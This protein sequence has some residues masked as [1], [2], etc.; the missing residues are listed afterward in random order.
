MKSSKFQAPSSRETSNSKFQ[1]IGQTRLIFARGCRFVAQ[2]CN[3]LYRRIEFCGGAIIATA[4]RF[5][6]A[7]RLQIGDTA[8]FNS[9]LHSDAFAQFQKGSNG[10]IPRAS[11]RVLGF[12]V[13]SFSGAW[14]LMFGA[15]KTGAFRK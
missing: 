3:L 14:S 1:R 5:A 13:W 8:E 15:L 12:D 7:S 4:P 11:S 6:T 2:I 9:A 10:K